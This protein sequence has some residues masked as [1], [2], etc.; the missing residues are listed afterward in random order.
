MNDDMHLL[1]RFAR[2]GV[3]KA[4]FDL[5]ALDP[6]YASR[7][8]VTKKMREWQALSEEGDQEARRKL[9]KL[10]RFLILG[11]AEKPHG[12]NEPD[13]E[14]AHHEI[15]QLV[16]DF[17]IQGYSK[18]KACKFVAKEYGMNLKLIKAICRKYL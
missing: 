7:D 5:V 6:S 13:A 9:E 10:R 4:I 8:Y 1:E 3:E 14:I 12:A 17:M 11:V 18:R 16:R 15:A 2:W